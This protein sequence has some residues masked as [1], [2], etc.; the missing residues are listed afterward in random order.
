MPSIAQSVQAAQSLDHNR[1]EPVE[2]T[3]RVNPPMPTPTP[4][5]SVRDMFL[6]CPLPPITSNPDSLRQFY[7]GTIPQ[8][9]ILPMAQ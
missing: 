2:P 3:P 9:R 7:R 5:A 6:R 1:F 8:T 4:V